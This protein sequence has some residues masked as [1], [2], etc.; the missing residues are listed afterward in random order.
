MSPLN[1]DK[2]SITSSFYLTKQTS[3]RIAMK[4]RIGVYI[5]HCGGNISDYVD[6]EQLSKLIAN[7]DNVVISKDVM[8]ACSDS[9]QKDMVQDINDQKLDAIVVASC[10]PKLHTH[11]FRN[12]AIRSGLNPYNYTQVNVREQ[13]SWAH[14]DKPMDATIK[15]YGLI[16]A[17]I[18]RVKYSEALENIE[19]TAQKAVGVIGAGISGMRAAVDLARMGNHVYLIEKEAN[20][21]GRV[22]ESGKLFMTGENGK[23]VID[24]L[25]KRI[26]EIPE[27]TVF[28]N[29]NLDK[30]SGSIGDFTLEVSVKDEALK[31]NVGAVLVTTGFDFYQPK[32]GEY[33]Y[34]LSDNVIT[35]QQFNKLIET[36]NDKL[37][38]NGNAIKSV[39]YI[40]CVGSRQSKGEN[41]YCS[42][43]CCSAAIHSS[44]NVHE[45]FSGVKAFHLYRDIRTYGKQELLYT[46]SSR[47]GDIYIKYEEK[48]PPAVEV[49]NNKTVITVKDYL[50]YKKELS[51]DVDLV[52]LVTGMVPRS[53]SNDISSKLKI[54]TGSD[55]FFNEI[56][57]K[58]KPVETVI[59]GVYI[60][61]TCQGPKNI[62]ESVQSS[63]AAASKINTILRKGTLELEPIVARV[64]A[65][66]CLW[67]E[68]CAAVCE[69]DA[70]KPIESNGKM[71]AQVNTSTCVGC[72]ICGPVCPSNS[73]EI[74]QFT[75]NEIE[76][77][78]DGFMEKAEINTKQDSQENEISSGKQIKLNGFPKIW[79]EIA[80]ALDDKTL[81]IPQLSEQLGV[82][83]N[84]LT[85]HLMT[86]NRYGVVEPAGLDEDEAYYMYKLKK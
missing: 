24:R 37:V 42:R 84:V 29:A 66:T 77:M 30:V 23:D 47:K 73:I 70:I 25:Y 38:Y 2:D 14:S 72:G 20:V 50:T 69:Y 56:H 80:S 71:I 54:P 59:K 33:G 6:V 79:R 21:G 8:F 75:D 1:D 41:K 31:L 65:E 19:I 81:T 63:L 61:G 26:K 15:A 44:L 22:A 40:Y 28:T 55:R 64:N 62:T 60:G 51:F 48:E 12:V 39:A 3:F 53:D 46:E 36:S 4:Q 35:L 34:K 52:V 11:T 58:L 9:T 68:K 83:S 17:G 45:K 57:P 43:Q 5:C 27:I 86:M 78:I 13:C 85:W 32:E 67:C 7:E 16:R 76:S 10:T 49:K 82:E 74:V 18:N